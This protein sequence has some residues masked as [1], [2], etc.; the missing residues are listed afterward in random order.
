MDF[1]VQSNP[2]ENDRQWFES[3]PIP[4]KSEKHKGDSQMNYLISISL[5]IGNDPFETMLLEHPKH[6]TVEILKNNQ[7]NYRLQ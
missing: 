5:D 7:M 3:C 2:N 1:V 4:E 6:N